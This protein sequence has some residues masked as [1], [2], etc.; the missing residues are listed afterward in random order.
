MDVKVK[1]ESS[2]LLIGDLSRRTDASPR[3]LRHYEAAGLIR[4]R[5]AANGSREYDP[6]TVTQVRRIRAL[7]AAG[8]NLAAVA[9]IL[10]CLDDDAEHLQMCPSV[11]AQVRR[12]LG[13]IAQQS[14]E[15]MR[16]RQEI[17]R[18]IGS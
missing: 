1:A 2:P 16:R 15:L 13:S 10:P 4:A 18:L 6:E 9:T 8:F 12:T 5:R 14:E 17:E 3:S 7:L 11:A